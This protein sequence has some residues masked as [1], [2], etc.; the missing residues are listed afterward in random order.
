MTDIY[1]QVGIAIDIALRYGDVEDA[2]HKDW[3]IDQMVRA[4]TITKYDEIIT[5]ARRRGYTWKVGSAP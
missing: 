5:E 3:V 2:Q 4:L 1:D